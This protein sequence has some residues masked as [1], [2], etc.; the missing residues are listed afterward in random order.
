MPKPLRLRFV[1][2]EVGVDD[3]AAADVGV[4][5]LAYPPALV[6]LCPAG[7]VTAWTDDSPLATS[8][9]QIATPVPPCAVTARE[10]EANV[11][12]V[13]PSIHEL[14]VGRTP[15][16]STTQPGVHLLILRKRAWGIGVSAGPDSITRSEPCIRTCR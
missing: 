3:G 12:R 13:P 4:Q 2:V 6:A 15:A 5:F 11:T 9:R 8:T 10:S 1:V 14:V 7:G 16:S